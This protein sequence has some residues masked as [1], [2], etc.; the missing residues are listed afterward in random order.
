ML[1]RGIQERNSA[2]RRARRF[3]GIAP[4]TGDRLARISHRFPWR[5]WRGWDPIWENLSPDWA[6]AQWCFRTEGRGVVLDSTLRRAFGACVSP[7]PARARW[8]RPGTT[9]RPPR[10]VGGGESTSRRENDAG[11]DASLAAAGSW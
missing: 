8:A 1:D 7:S 3:H 5:G 10:A 6:C 9:P 2:F 11:C 4:G